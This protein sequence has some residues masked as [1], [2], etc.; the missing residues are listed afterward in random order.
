[1]SAVGG[2]TTTFPSTLHSGSNQLVHATKNLTISVRQYIILPQIWKSP[3]ALAIFP[4]SASVCTISCK[5]AARS[6]GVVIGNVQH[7][8]RRCQ[9]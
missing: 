5:V 1:M 9:S 7:Q 2:S 6:I 3:D 8:V 4:D